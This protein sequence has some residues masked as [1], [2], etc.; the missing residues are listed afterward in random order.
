MSQPS[1][2]EVEELLNVFIKQSK[3]PH[4]PTLQTASLKAAQKILMKDSLSEE[5]ANT[6]FE[7]PE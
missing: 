1:L 7:E 5:Q 3:D 2:E 6:F 4:N